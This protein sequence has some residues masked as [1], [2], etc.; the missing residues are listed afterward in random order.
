MSC[1]SEKKNLFVILLRRADHDSP[2]PEFCDCNTKMSQEL[3]DGPVHK[4]CFFLPHVLFVLLVYF[5]CIIFSNNMLFD[6]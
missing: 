5:F 3:D 2:S 1:R 4:V 6:K